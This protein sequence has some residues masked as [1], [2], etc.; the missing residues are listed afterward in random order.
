[1]LDGRLLAQRRHFVRWRYGLD[2]RGWDND[3]WFIR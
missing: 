1:M 3:L 2:D